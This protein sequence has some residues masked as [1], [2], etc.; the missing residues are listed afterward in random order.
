MVPACLWVCLVA[1][2]VEMRWTYEHIGDMAARMLLYAGQKRWR[3]SAAA[4]WVRS[5]VTKAAPVPAT[6]SHFS[7]EGDE[8][9]IVT[10]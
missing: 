9:D 10:D 1:G 4:T 7:G 8:I 5:V 6:R 2:G 3:G